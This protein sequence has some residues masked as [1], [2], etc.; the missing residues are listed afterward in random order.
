MSHGPGQPVAPRDPRLRDA[1]RVAAKAYREHIGGPQSAD[2]AYKA[3]AA[4]V[5]E[6]M[7]ELS[8]KEASV[9]AVEAVSY[10]SWAHPKWLYALQ[11]RNDDEHF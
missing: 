1:W 9:V 10:A 4:T 11:E 6:L 7:P 8:Q 5:L 2:R 3:A